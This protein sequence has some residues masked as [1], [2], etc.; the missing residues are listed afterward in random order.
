MDKKREQLMIKKEV[1]F[2][3]ICAFLIFIA[4]C[5]T[6]TGAVKGA[7]EGAKKDWAA[8]EGA[9]DWMQENFW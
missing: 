4:G 3:I 1:I 2:L 7:C 6:L 9:D 5:Q 8:I